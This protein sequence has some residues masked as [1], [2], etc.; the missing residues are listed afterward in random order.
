MTGYA[1]PHPTP[2][3]EE[4][5]ASPSITWIVAAALLCG[6][7]LFTVLYAVI[8]IAGGLVDWVWWIGAMPLVLGF[9]MLLNP[10]AGPQGVE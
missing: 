7:G 3:G 10:R 9:F 4:S 8:Q 1:R 6:V 2:S 5:R